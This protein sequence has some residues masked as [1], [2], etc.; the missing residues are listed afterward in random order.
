MNLLDVVAGA[1]G[2]A[3]L[4][5]WGTFLFGDVQRRRYVRGTVRWHNA[6]RIRSWVRPLVLPVFYASF[7]LDVLS[8]LDDRLGWIAF[9]VG[10]NLLMLWILKNLADLEKDDDDDPWGNL[11]R[12]IKDWLTTPVSL[13][14]AAGSPA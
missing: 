1:V 8:S 3:F 4:I 11:G 6:N 14:A 9:R 5:L 2:W 13:P 7:A 10:M 12:K